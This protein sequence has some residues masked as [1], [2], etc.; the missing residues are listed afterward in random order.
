MAVELLFA[1]FG[2]LVVELTFAVFVMVVPVAV[3]ALMFTVRLNVALAPA[4]SEAM[5]H[6]TVAPVVQ[7]NV[8]PDVCVSETNVVFA[9]SVSV[10]E[11]VVAVDGPAFAAVIV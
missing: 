11:T 3:P 7:L 6:A 1:V 2:S 9:G 4:L 5:L 8:G 10:H